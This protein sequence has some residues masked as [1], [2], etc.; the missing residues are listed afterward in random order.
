MLKAKEFKFMKL[1]S[2][3]FLLLFICFSHLTVSARD[4]Y[5]RG[6]TRS[7]G[8]Y[9]APH[10]R[11]SPDSNPYNNYSTRGNTNPYTGK[12]GTVNPYGS[13]NSGLN[14]LNSNFG[15]SSKLGNYRY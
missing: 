9:V 13:R 7:N 11:S 1:K 12:A 5:V 14:S 10:H 3:V 4:V 15:S 8:T 2:F 6:Y